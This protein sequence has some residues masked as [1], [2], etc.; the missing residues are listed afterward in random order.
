MKRSTDRILTTHTGSL[1]RSPEVLELLLAEDTGASFDRDRFEAAVRESV[2]RVVEKQLEAGLDVV[3]DGEQGKISFQRYRYRRLSGFELVDA[4]EAGVEQRGPPAEARDFPEFYNRWFEQWFPSGAASGSRPAESKTLCCTGPIGWRDFSAVERDLANLQG[5]VQGARVEEVFMT[6]ISPATYLPPNLYYPS[7]GEYLEATADAMA[8]EYEAIVEAGFLLQ[9]DAPDLTTMYRLRDMPLAE[10][11]GRLEL[12]VDAINRGL[13]NVPADRVRVHVCWGADEAP[14]HRDVP[15]TEIVDALL[16]L[17]AQGLSI[18]GANGR[19]A[20]EWRV[21]G[22]VAL[23]D[24]KLLVPGVVD[25]TTNI[26]E[27]PEAVA[28]RIVR[29]ASVVGR[30]TVVAGVD[31]GFGTVAH[32]QLID[33]RIV[34]AKLR[35][36]AEGAALATKALW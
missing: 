28:E 11:R 20:H 2:A 24:D 25:S 16:R 22:D 36:L 19:H 10:F 35:A 27:H 8:R 12:C 30:E 33:E 32:V 31:C 23:P 18:A 4:A 17:K 26:I 9:V 5:A 6:A 21:W 15:L 3:N 1:P 29:Y 13:R 34:W 7:E 14:H